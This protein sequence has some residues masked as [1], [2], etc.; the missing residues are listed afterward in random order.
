MLHC[1]VCLNAPLIDCSSPSLMP[2]LVLRLICADMIASRTPLLNDLHRLRRLHVPERITYKLFVLV[3]TLRTIVGRAVFLLR[4]LY[5]FYS[6]NNSST[7]S[8]RQIA[9]FCGAM[10]QNGM[11]SARRSEARRVESG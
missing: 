10:E 5:I 2:L 8:G 9:E 11:L 3:N 4:F 1:W 6:R 7:V